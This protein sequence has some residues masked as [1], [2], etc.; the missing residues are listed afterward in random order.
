MIDHED[1]CLT[2][3][4]FNNIFGDILLTEGQCFKH[5][6]L[7]QGIGNALS[8]IESEGQFAFYE[9]DFKESE[10]ELLSRVKIFEL[11][12]AELH[13]ST[14]QK[15]PGILNSIL[16]LTNKD[17]DLLSALIKKQAQYIVTAEKADDARVVIKTRGAYSNGGCD[18]WHID[19]DKNQPTR[20]MG[21]EQV[22]WKYADRLHI[23]TLVG[24]GT[25]YQEINN[26]ERE[27]FHQIANETLSYYGHVKGCESGDMITK[28]FSNSDKYVVQIGL[29]AVHRLG[30]YGSLHKAPSESINGRMLLMITPIYQL[31][32]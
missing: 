27:I 24:E 31:K 19:K 13:L 1:G 21:E 2:T 18:Y 22:G 5:E 32:T 8:Y 12:E 20:E 14:M 9:L 25:E 4:Y 16:E 23:I 3:D 11:N 10:Q 17:I 6:E 7:D 28:L 29:G 26:Q 30:E 15:L